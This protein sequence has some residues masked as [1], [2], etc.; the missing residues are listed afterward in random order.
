[1]AQTAIYFSL[2]SV[3]SSSNNYPC[4]WQ[5]EASGRRLENNLLQSN[6]LGLVLKLNCFFCFF[7][8][9]NENCLCQLPVTARK[10]FSLWGLWQ[11]C[12]LA[13]ATLLT[14]ADGCSYKMLL[15]H[16]CVRPWCHKELKSLLQSHAGMQWCSGAASQSL[17]IYIF[18][19]Q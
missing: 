17:N 5:H 18:Q 6:A 2:P 15:G 4:K 11:D 14:T 7:F 8:F 3:V 1:M 16:W 19:R 9:Q 12:L 10:L 13:S